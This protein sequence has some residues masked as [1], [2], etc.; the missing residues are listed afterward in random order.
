MNKGCLYACIG[1]DILEIQVPG[2]I[3]RSVDGEDAVFIQDLSGSFQKNFRLFQFGVDVVG[4]YDRVGAVRL[5]LFP[6][7]G[8]FEVRE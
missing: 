7:R 6:G 5:D 8:I 3:V 1:E 4:K 2:G